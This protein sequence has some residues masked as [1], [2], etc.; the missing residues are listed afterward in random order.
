MRK[1]TRA[2]AKALAAKLVKES[3]GCPI[4][5]RTWATIISDYEDKL[6]E[7]GL[8]RKQVPWVLDHDHDTGKCR[9]VLCRGCN[10]AE[11]KVANIAATWGKA[12]RDTKAT[13]DWVHN[14]SDY[15]KTEPLDYIYPTHQSVE[16]QK[17]K[18][19]TLRKEVARKRASARR[20]QIVERRSNG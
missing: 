2:Q 9:G 5:K 16:E 11:G 8:K 12:G 19:S 10:G 7:K 4:C 1:L 18:K 17:S 20:K 14:L 13:A 6:K 3:K 15:L